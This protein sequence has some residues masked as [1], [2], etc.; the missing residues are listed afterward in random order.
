[1]KENWYILFNDMIIVIKAE[2]KEE[3]MVNF[4]S[5]F[6]GHLSYSMIGQYSQLS[7]NVK[8]MYNL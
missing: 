7:D 8:R 6:G 2:S 5:H 1:M 4:F 3:V